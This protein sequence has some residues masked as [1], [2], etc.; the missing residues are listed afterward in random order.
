[1]SKLEI[2]MW[3]NTA[4]AICGTILN[5]KQVRF[6]FILWMITNAVFIVNNIYMKSLPQAALFTVYLGLAVFGYI[7]WGKAA[8]A[9]DNAP[10]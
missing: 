4:V 9:K 7:S 1:M 6:G 8:K 5:A 3:C 2:L 10:S